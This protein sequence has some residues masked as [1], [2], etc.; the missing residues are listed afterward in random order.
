M[1]SRSA[2]VSSR[3][4]Y[5]FP[6]LPR[7]LGLEHARRVELVVVYRDERLR[8]R[9]QS[10]VLVRLELAQAATERHPPFEIVVAHAASLS[11]RPNGSDTS[12]GHALGCERASAM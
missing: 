1:T 11:A 6:T 10:A 3:R 9:R 7:I 12:S 8:K 4:S 2:P 5:A